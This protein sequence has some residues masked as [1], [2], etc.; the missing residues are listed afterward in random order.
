MRA[1]R[2]GGWLAAVVLGHLLV[3]VLHGRAHDGGHVAL[4]AAQS[5]FV[6]VVILAGP[7]A[8]LAV[9]FASR[10]AGGAIVALTMAASLLFGLINHFIIV[11]PDHV[12]QVAPEWRSLFAST[13]VLLM[14]TEAAGVV[15]GLR[16]I[17]QEVSS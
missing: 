17:G 1:K 5:L 7:L 3:S 15:A 10:R 14:L 13:A 8:G 6:F 11:S 2:F 4:T 16:A 9:T 12:S